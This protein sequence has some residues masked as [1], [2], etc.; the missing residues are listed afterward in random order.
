[1]P[2]NPPIDLS[3][4]PQAR[5]ST[6]SARASA[7]GADSDRGDDNSVRLQKTLRL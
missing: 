6:R 2:L 1:M 4:G 5:L 3:N 7:A